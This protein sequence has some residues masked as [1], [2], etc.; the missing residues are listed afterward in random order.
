MHCCVPRVYVAI[1]CFDTIACNF[2]AASIHLR[3]PS[4]VGIRLKS[5]KTTNLFL[6]FRKSTEPMRLLGNPRQFL[7][8]F[9]ESGLQIFFP[10][11]FYILPYT[12]D[13]P[14][15]ARLVWIRNGIFIEVVFARLP[16]FKLLQIDLIMQQVDD[17]LAWEG[18]W[19]WPLQSRARNDSHGLWQANVV[20]S[21]DLRNIC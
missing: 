12:F 9:P 6:D 7:S 1:P 8:G 10:L 15:L 20:P 3:P 16:L 5:A 21:H 14:F 13:Y 2:V 11:P 18:F 19:F 4:P 17:S